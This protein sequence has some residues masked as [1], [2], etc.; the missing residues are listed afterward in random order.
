[1]IFHNETDL[2]TVFIL[3]HGENETSHEEVNLSLAGSDSYGIK[4]RTLTF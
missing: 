1:M 3:Q 2:R 4:D